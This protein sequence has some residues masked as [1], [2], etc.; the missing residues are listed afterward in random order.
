MSK[1]STNNSQIAEQLR[2]TEEALAAQ[3]HKNQQIE[4]MFKRLRHDYMTIFD[5]VPAMI[6]YRDKE[7]RVL[8]TNKFAADSLGMDIKDV[9]G[10]NYYELF[11]DGA[12][13]AREKDLEVILT[14]K[15]IRGQIREFRT[16][17]GQTRWAIADRI[18]YRDKKGSLAF[19]EL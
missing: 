10:R 16:A 15:P 14:G 5:S 19:V 7:G 17:S 8:R 4:E 13:K 3:I 18:P 11:A 12:E 6:W 9:I 1:E 2:E